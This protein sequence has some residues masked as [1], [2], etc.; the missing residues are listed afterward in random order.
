M[1]NKSLKK[2]KYQVCWLTEKCEKRNN[3]LEADEDQQRI[4]STALE[5][6]TLYVL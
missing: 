2:E 4:E 3:A 5:G 1:K 6:P